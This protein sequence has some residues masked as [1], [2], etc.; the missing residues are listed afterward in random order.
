M[1]RVDILTGR[2]FSLLTVLERH[3][4]NSAQG[5]AR[6]VCRCECG[7]RT[8]VRGNDLKTAKVKSCGARVHYPD[9]RL[10]R[11][12]YGAAHGRVVRD[13]G[14]ASEHACVGCGDR[15]ADWSYDHSDPG[16]LISEAPGTLGYRYSCDPSYYLPRCRPCHTIYDVSRCR[17]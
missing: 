17:S 9:Q 15:A 16:E 6:W 14:R 2:S 4:E 1:A 13:R 12:E 8:V 11:V 10:P 7:A 3:P 5:K